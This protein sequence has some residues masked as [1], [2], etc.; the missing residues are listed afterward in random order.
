MR[1]YISGKILASFCTMP[2][3]A[4]HRF[5]WPVRRVPPRGGSIPEEGF[6]I[7]SRTC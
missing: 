4:G 3:G 2:R 6:R 5:L 7:G 1:S